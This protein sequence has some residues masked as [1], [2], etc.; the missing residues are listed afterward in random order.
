MSNLETAQAI[1]EAFGRGDIEFILEQV[2]DDIRWDQ[3]ESPGP[4]HGGAVPTLVARAGKAGV[5]EFFAALA[6]LEFH[7]FM[8]TNLLEG[9]N[10]V[11]A[12]AEI[13]AT[14]QATGTRIRD[15]EVHLMTFDDD[16]K[17]VELR[18]ILDTAKALDAYGH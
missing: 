11:A 13:D 14:V 8:I 1:Y 10:Q 3:R 7:D 18:H 12:I 2:A 5:G 15:T 17:I 16:G 6:G 9:S 4:A